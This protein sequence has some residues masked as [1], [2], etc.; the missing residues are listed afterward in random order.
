MEMFRF[1]QIIM[2]KLTLIDIPYDCSSPGPFP[3]TSGTGAG[4]AD[5]ERKN[6]L[7]ALALFWGNSNK[8]KYFPYI[9]FKA[10]LTAYQ[11]EKYE[12]SYFCNFQPRTRMN[13][14]CFSLCVAAFCSFCYMLLCFSSYKAVNTAFKGIIKGL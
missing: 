9:P 11:D 2:W 14:P 8:S 1:N 10:V 6:S 12:S 5:L 4:Q 13:L 3:E 7:T